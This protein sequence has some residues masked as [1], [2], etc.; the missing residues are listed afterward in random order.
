MTLRTF[1]LLIGRRYRD[2]SG[3]PFVV[4]R[5]RAQADGAMA[6][7]VTRPPEAAESG[8]REIVT[9]ASHG[10]FLPDKPAA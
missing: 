7:I 3:Q 2:R 6:A 10:P 8:A 5:L 1:Q 4:D 9:D